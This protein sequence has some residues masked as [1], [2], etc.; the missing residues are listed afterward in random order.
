MRILGIESSCD[1]TALALV[2]K[3]GKAFVI[4]KHV[5]ASQI[6]THARYGG[7]VPEVAAREHAEK[8]FDLLSEI[9]VPRDGQDIDAIAVTIGPGLVPALRVG[10]ELAKCLA[11]AWHKPLV[12]VNHLE[13]HIYSVWDPACST[14]PRF[15]ALC[16]L[17]SGGHTEL[18]FMKDHGVYQSIGMTRDDAAGEAFDKVA[19][20][21]GLSYPG[22]PE[23]SRLAKEGDPNAIVFPRPMIDSSDFDFSF[24]GLKTAVKNYLSKYP[25]APVADIAASFQQ[26]V[27]ETLVVKT[28]RA[29]HTYKPVSVILTGGVS[30]NAPLREMLR[31]QILSP[32]SNRSFH[33]P[34]LSLTGDNAVMIAIAGAVRFQNGHTA[35]PLTLEAKP[36]L[37]L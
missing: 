33:V 11:W 18:V 22:G 7:I 17:V 6:K 10:V 19:K 12:S 34:E 35:D 29:V 4:E 5:L 27:I 8:I 3:T 37:P 25:T 2:T 26:A 16:L 32:D 30:A 14:I 28:V 24:S 23:I 9:P 31:S 13:G 21:L 20:L 1:E 36:N 15:P